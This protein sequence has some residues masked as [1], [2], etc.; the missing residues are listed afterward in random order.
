MLKDYYDRTEAEAAAV[1]VRSNYHTHVYLCEHAVGDACD[2]VREAVRNGLDTIGISDHCMPSRPTGMRYLTQTTLKTLYLPLIAAAKKEYGDKIKIL[3]AVELEYFDG[4]DGYYRKLLDSL[5]YLVL[6]Q[7]EYCDGYA[8][9]DSFCDYADDGRV[10]AYCKSVIA[11]VRTGMFSVLAHPDLI[12]YR[13]PELT[14]N[15]KKSF[16]EMIRVAA[17][18]G[19]AVEF[20]AN[21]IRSHGFRYPTDLLAE[22]CAKYNAP[23][24]VS[25][26]CHKPQYLCDGYVKRLRAYVV[27][28][29]LNL[30]ETINLPVK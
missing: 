20:N 6:G 28:C 11:A 22:C 12:F 23:I 8:H 3:S 5:D 13:N 2:Y 24:V 10:A 19:V 14:K 29:G 30:V 25:S 7:H 27:K 4:N 18:C 21:G 26:D 1:R 17:E 16:A 9:Y 15:V